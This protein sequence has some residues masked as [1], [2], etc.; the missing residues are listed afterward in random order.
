MSGTMSEDRGSAQQLGRSGT[1]GPDARFLACADTDDRRLIVKYR[2]RTVAEFC[3]SPALAEAIRVMADVDDM[4]IMFVGDAFSGKTALLI[5]IIREYYQIPRCAPIPETNVLFINSLGE[6]G[7]GFYRTDIKTFCKSRCTIPGRKKMIVVDDI[8]ALTEQSQH[9]FRNHID[10]Y[11]HNVNFVSAC[12]NPQKVVASLQS[13]LH[14]VRLEKPS[15]A[16]VGALI[17]SVVEN[18]AIAVDAGALELMLGFCGHSVCAMLNYLEKTRILDVPVSS[19]SEGFSAG[20]VGALELITDV[21]NEEFRRYIELVRA[22]SLGGA[23]AVLYDI[24]D[25]GYSV[26]DILEY[27]F[28]FV[29][30]TAML[31]DGEKYAVVEILCRY[32][33]V[34][35]TAHEDAVEL[36]LMTN[37]MLGALESDEPLARQLK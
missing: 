24:Y 14:S 8:D 1:K 11:G 21:S 19:S 13:R 23:I 30:S 25:C 37:N 15:A 31:A 9:V 33:A 10:K 34:F 20:E 16:Q 6:H 18:E 26:I 29:K 32:I 5:A 7:I 2:P 17:R 28:A 4:S 3:I 35:N 22:R 12:T 27:L 36:A